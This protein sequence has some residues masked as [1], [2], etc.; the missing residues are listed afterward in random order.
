MKIT[1]HQN[2][3]AKTIDLTLDAQKASVV[4][5]DVSHT[6]EHLVGTGHHVLLN[7]GRVTQVSIL[8]KHS[9]DKVDVLVNGAFHTL[10]IVDEKRKTSSAT[11]MVSAKEVKS[12]MPGRVVKINVKEGDSINAGDPML[13][14]EAMKMENEIKAATGGII[15]KIFVAEGA[16]VETGTMLVRIS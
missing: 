5:G 11:S 4:D 2:D 9:G 15:E 13:V 7:D 10:T 1:L 3:V 8:R 6:F 12:V 14:L 16:T